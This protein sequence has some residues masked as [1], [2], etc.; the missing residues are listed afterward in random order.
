MS[1]IQERERLHDYSI[2]TVRIM[3]ELFGWKIK[4]SPR[5]MRGPDVVMEQ[6]VIDEQGREKITAVMFIESEVGHD[7]GGAPEYFENLAK[8]LSK[9][10]KKY[11]DQG[12]GLISIAIVSNAPR[13]LSNY[14]R[15]NRGE[16]ARL[17]G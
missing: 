15:E 17:L 11:K 1:K 7:Q 3:A 12:V 5:Q 2:E 4:V 8:R 16:V 10:I 14:F 6:T 9:Y 13:R